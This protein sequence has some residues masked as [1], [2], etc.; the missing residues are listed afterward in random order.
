[1]RGEQQ[2]VAVLEL[3]FAPLVRR[4]MTAL[5]A[6]PAA[7]REVQRHRFLLDHRVQWNV[8][9]WCRLGALRPPRAEHAV[10][11]LHVAPHF[12]LISPPSFRSRRDF[13][14]YRTL[15]P[16]AGPVSLFA[17]LYTFL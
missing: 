8:A 9:R 6:D 14:Y 12:P 3:E 13:A 10:E 7:F 11:D 15:P 17:L 16:A 1:M 4:D 5:R 2:L